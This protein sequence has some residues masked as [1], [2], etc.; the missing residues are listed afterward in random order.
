[1]VLIKSK[2]KKKGSGVGINF[3]KVIIHRGYFKVIRNEKAYFLFGFFPKRSSQKVQLSKRCEKL[4][5]LN[6]EN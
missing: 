3:H 1:L 2:R 4:A 6:I 5:F